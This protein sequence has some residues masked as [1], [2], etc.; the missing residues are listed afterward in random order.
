MLIAQISDPHVRPAGFLYQGVVDSNGMFEQALK[1]IAAL[2]PRPD[3]LLLTGDLVD[4]GRAEE[5]MEL[6]RLLSQCVVPFRVIPGNHDDRE[7]FRAAFSDQQYLP[8]GGALHYCLDEF[9]VR[10]VALDSC[11][12]NRHHGNLDAQGLEWLERTL[13]ADGLK[14]TLLMLHHPPFV[15]GIPYLDSYRFL[16]PAPLEALLRR[17]TNIELVVCGHVHRTMWRRWAGTIVCACP[18]TTT[19]IALQL[20]A[21]APPLSFVGPRGCLL[22]RWTPGDG[23]VTHLSNIGDSAGPYP[24]A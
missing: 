10:I 18:S 9:D 19:E 20:H 6:R 21:D 1:H 22:H 11:V 15:S 24:F 7:Q 13:D 2:N 14:P 12:P 23:I 3:L 4:E 5:Y 8:R 16:E 17:F